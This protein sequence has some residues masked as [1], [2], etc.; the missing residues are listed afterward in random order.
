MSEKYQFY[1]GLKFT[2]DEKTGYYLNSTRKIRIHHIDFDKSNNSISNLQLLSKSKHKAL[3]GR[4]CGI[5]N[6]KNGL[7]DKIRP[8]T[9]K[10]HASKEGSA[11]HK[12][13]YEAMKDKLYV[14]K[15][16]TCINCG[17]KY[18]SICNGEN[19]FC[20]NACKSSYRRKSGVD[21]IEEECVICG[22]KFT[23]NK[24]SKTKTCSRK[25]ASK[26]KK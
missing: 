25:C 11:W 10:W 7:L 23:K 12:T 20:S 18:S 22:K 15:N 5:L 26:Y 16:F 19:K 8:M 13:H 14:S 2:R 9:K 6:V 17:K 1:N 24:Y 3:H 4:L 21:N